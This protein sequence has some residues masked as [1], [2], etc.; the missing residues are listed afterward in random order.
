[1]TNEHEKRCPRCGET[2]PVAG[3]FYKEAKAK[4][5]FGGYCIPC[6]KARAIAWQK[7]NPD[8]KK[9]SDRIQRQKQK[10]ERVPVLCSCGCGLL[11]KGT[12]RGLPMFKGHGNRGKRHIAR[13][14][15]FPDGVMLDDADRINLEHYSWSLAGN[16]YVQRHAEKSGGGWTKVRLHRE[17]MGFPNAQ[18]D[19]INGDKLD[20][21]RE[22]M[23]VVD[24]QTNSQ[25][26]ATATETIS[27][28]RGVS[29][30]KI[31]GDWY[32][33]GK[34]NGKMVSLGFFENLEDASRA[35]TEFRRK[36]YKGFVDR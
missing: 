8:K 31:Y 16:G 26:H 29:W 17:I 18:I 36:H 32:A 20:C 11:T 9:S 21:R 15:G 5:G 19:H 25:N 33:Y 27:G 34:M 23:R 4:D 7:A 30:R 3:N 13:S 12:A 24:N 6:V 35:A 10:A 1:M 14:P 28:V 2:K 22:N